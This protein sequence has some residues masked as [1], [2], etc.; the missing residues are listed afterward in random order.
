MTRS[1]EAEYARWPAAPELQA[2]PGALNWPRSKEI[3]HK[4]KDSPMEAQVATSM[5]RFRYSSEV[6]RNKLRSG[7]YY[8]GYWLDHVVWL[9][10]KVVSWLGL[11]SCRRNPFWQGWICDHSCISL[12]TK[13]FWIK[14]IC[15]L[16]EGG[17]SG[18]IVLRVCRQGHFWVCK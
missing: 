16:C 17:G 7:G 6:V 2:W 4:A 14:I 1:C 18:W 15:T 12:N 5:L 10:L 13:L 8:F 3:L 9:K 11:F